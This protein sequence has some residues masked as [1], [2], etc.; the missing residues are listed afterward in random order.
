MITLLMPMSCLFPRRARGRRLVVGPPARRRGGPHHP[1]DGAAETRPGSASLRGLRL[2]RGGQ[3]PALRHLPS[4]SVDPPPSA[5]APATLTAPAD[6]RTARRPRPHPRETAAL[7]RPATPGRP[8]APPLLPQ[9]RPRRHP[10]GTAA[11]SVIAPS[12]RAPSHRGDTAARPIA[13]SSGREPFPSPPRRGEPPYRR[14][15]SPFVAARDTGLSVRVFALRRRCCALLPAGASTTRRD[16]RP[17]SSPPSSSPVEASA[18]GGGRG[19]CGAF[20]DV[21]RETFV[22]RAW[23]QKT[24]ARGRRFRGCWERIWR[25]GATA[26]RAPARPRGRLPGTSRRSRRRR[27]RKHP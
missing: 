23:A 3:D 12:G 4:S 5:E 18:R 2:W 10:V 26:P 27:I 14:S 8:L 22:P 13:A 15:S 16:G 11:H 21:S 1:G 7:P 25:A 9:P 24:P 17:P 19:S 20:R 6:A